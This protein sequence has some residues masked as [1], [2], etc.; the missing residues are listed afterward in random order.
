MLE[1]IIMAILCLVILGYHYVFREDELDINIE[2]EIYKLEQAQ[3]KDKLKSSK[4]IGVYNVEY[5]PEVNEGSLELLGIEDKH[6]LKTRYY[7]LENGYQLVLEDYQDIYL[8]QKGDILDYHVFNKVE[9]DS[10]IK[11][12]YL[13]DK[14]VNEVVNI[15]KA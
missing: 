3:Y 14:V 4:V 13:T 11:E 5:I 9:Y 7:E 6:K 10:E 2:E 12:A 8:I 15:R 1:L